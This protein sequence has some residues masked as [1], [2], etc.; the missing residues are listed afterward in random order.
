MKR[1]RFWAM[2]FL[3]CF[4]VCVGNLGYCSSQEG[5]L[6]TESPKSNEY[7]EPGKWEFI[8]EKSF[9]LSVEGVINEE[10]FSPKVDHSISP[11][12]EYFNE[13]NSKAIVDYLTE[14]STIKKGMMIYSL[15]ASDQTP[16]GTI[17]EF[18]YD[19]PLGELCFEFPKPTQE[20]ERHSLFLVSKE[21][22]KEIAKIPLKNNQ[23]ANFT[24]KIQ[25]KLQEFFMQNT[26][27]IPILTLKEKAK[28]L[29]S[30]ELKK[31]IEKKMTIQNVGVSS[32]PLMEKLT[33]IDG[34]FH[35]FDDDYSEEFS[36]IFFPDGNVQVLPNFSIIDAFLANGKCYFWGSWNYPETGWNEYR[37]FQTEKNK[38]VNVFR[39][40]AFSN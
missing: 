15:N 24:L 23:E 38:I 21:P 37:V 11:L 30:A 8:L 31:Y 12:K 1:N 16:I 5:I 29:N 3:V 20:N 10:Y 36:A 40:G 34:S 33:I 19:Y 4:G 6:Q 35:P 17:K 2:L 39:E 13:S 26:Q 25:K 28:Q 22:L 7:S 14:K 18:H 9:F 27:F 32:H